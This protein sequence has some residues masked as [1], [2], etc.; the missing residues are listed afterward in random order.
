MFPIKIPKWLLGAVWLRGR[1]EEEEDKPFFMNGCGRSYL[2][3][4]VTPPQ[5]P[6]P[7]TKFPGGLSN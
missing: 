4:S 2:S 5:P 7:L 6:N 3:C 1:E